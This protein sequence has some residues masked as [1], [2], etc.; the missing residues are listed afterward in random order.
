MLNCAL[1]QGISIHLLHTAKAATCLSFPV[2]VFATNSPCHVIFL[3]AP[4][5]HQQQR[6][7]HT[8]ATVNGF[9]TRC[10]WVHSAVLV[11]ECVGL[12][13][14]VT[15]GARPRGQHG[16]AEGGWV[17]HGA[18]G[19]HRI[20]ASSNSPLRWLTL[21]PKARGPFE[22]VISYVSGMEPSSSPPQTS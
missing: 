9:D 3:W 10:R 22:P 8:G 1:A 17:V 15:P 20:A 18:G 2:S 14:L 11:R 7:R 16:R 12:L 4:S 5:R 19:A 21:A 13:R 6:H